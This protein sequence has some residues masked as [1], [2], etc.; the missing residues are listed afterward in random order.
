MS[1]IF[2]CILTSDDRQLQLFK[3]ADDRL[4]LELESPHGAV[5]T[6]VLDREEIRRVQSFLNE[7]FGE[8]YD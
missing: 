4:F 7:R 5:E 3:T 2:E 1:L 8:V 6:I